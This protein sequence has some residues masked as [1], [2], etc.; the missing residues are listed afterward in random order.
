VAN[1]VVTQTEA[2][3]D[4]IPNFKLQYQKSNG[5]LV[6]P[7]VE[8]VTKLGKSSFIFDIQDNYTTRITFGL[9]SRTKDTNVNLNALPKGSY[10]ISCDIT[11][12]TQGS[13]SWKDMQI[14]VNKDG[15]ATPYEPYKVGETKTTTIA[16]GA[17]FTS[18]APNMT[19]ITDTAGVVIDCTYNRDINIAFERLTQAIISIGGI[20]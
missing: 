3:A 16:D 6:T 17:E 11:N 10:I 14:E 15:M 19:I 20:I 2:Q 7:F 8:S 18:I 5:E 1:G 4:D 13:I 9:N 12:L